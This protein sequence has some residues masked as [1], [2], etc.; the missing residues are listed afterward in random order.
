[1]LPLRE[2][3]WYILKSH[4]I[5]N[6]CFKSHLIFGDSDVIRSH[7]KSCSVSDG[8]L[9]SAFWLLLT[10]SVQCM[11]LEGGQTSIRNRTFLAASKSFVFTV[12]CGSW[13]VTKCQAAKDDLKVVGNLIANELYFKVPVFVGVK[14]VDVPLP[15]EPKIRSRHVANMTMNKMASNNNL[16]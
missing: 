14:V 8:L 15:P 2:I 9:M 12:D 16:T 7:I 5:S 4:L 13:N 6:L 11:A 3:L 1:M 10:L